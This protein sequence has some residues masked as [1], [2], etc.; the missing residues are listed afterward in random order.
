MAGGDRGSEIMSELA[1]A[2]ALRDEHRSVPLPE[3]GT[4]KSRALLQAKLYLDDAG[5][6]GPT[7][8]REAIGRLAQPLPEIFPA[9]ASV[10]DAEWREQNRRDLALGHAVRLAENLPG[11]VRPGEDLVGVDRAIDL[12]Q[13]VAAMAKVF[14]TMLAG[15]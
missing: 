1:E 10:A 14:A 3:E 4:E 15:G 13:S 11:L 6:E 8:L 2:G 9:V 5:P 7:R 12:A